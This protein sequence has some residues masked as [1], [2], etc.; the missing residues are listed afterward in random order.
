MRNRPYAVILCV[1]RKAIIILNRLDSHN[2]QQIRNK[3]NVMKSLEKL[4]IQIL[5]RRYI[6]LLS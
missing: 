6:V 5:M 2:K 1:Y 4:K 3:N